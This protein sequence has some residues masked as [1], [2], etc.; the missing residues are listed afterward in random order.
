VTNSLPRPPEHPRSLVYFGSPETAVPALLAL[1]DAEFEIPLVISMPDRR[2]SRRA[3][4]TATP[5]KAAAKNLGIPVS[6]EVADALTVEADCGV[7]VAYG[8]LIDRTLLAQL[9]MINLHFSLLP[10]WRGA[11]PV[12]RA[13]LAGDTTTG[14]CVMGLEPELDTGPVYRRCETEISRHTTAQELS[15]ELAKLGAEELVASIQE[16][17]KDPVPQ[18]GTPT[19]A[20][21]INRSDLR[22]DW[23]LSAVELDRVVRVGGAWTTNESSLLKIHQT[24]VVS[25]EGEPGVLDHDLVG[26][27]KDLLQLLVVQAEGKSRMNADA[28]ING[29]HL[30][31]KARL[32]T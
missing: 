1:L 14:V 13:I 18:M 29:A 17:L 32:G 19:T 16:G 2:R 15:E 22:L 21:K 8:R 23:D 24:R 30:G 28:W 31:T 11:A 9:P 3:A 7:V 12:E 5:V 10:R 25:G 26:T 6:E 20:N 4:P 27:S